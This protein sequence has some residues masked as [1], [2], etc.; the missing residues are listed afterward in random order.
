MTLKI[1][2]IGGIASG[3]T[4]ALDFFKSEGIETFSADEIARQLTQM[5]NPCFEAILSHCGPE[6]LLPNGELDRT[7]LRQKIM[8]EPSFK[9]WLESLLHPLIQEVLIK[10]ILECTGP[11][12][13]VEIPLLK[14]KNRYHLDRVLYIKS[15][16]SEQK[17]RLESRGLSKEHI[18]GM[19]KLQIPEQHRNQLADDIIENNSTYE[20][21]LKKLQAIHQQYLNLSAQKT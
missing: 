12:C 16:E 4:T 13:I 3:K 20:N 6:F 8:I 18:E 21:F 11:Y 1:G 15:S 2:L 9:T 17:K 14:E 5:N 7:L 19:L 10:N